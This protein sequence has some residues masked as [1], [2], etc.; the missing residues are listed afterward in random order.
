MALLVLHF[1][2]VEMVN[3]KGLYRQVIAWTSRLAVITLE[4]LDTRPTE[5][6]TAIR[7]LRLFMGQILAYRT[8]PIIVQKF[9]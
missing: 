7:L 2:S 8:E 3:K 9:V 4:V 6:M 5:T 1:T